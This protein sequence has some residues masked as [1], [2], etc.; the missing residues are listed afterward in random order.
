MD[1]ADGRYWELDC[2]SSGEHGGSAPCLQVL[3]HDEAVKKFKKNGRVEADA[4]A[5]RIGYLVEF[6]LVELGGFGC[7]APSAFFAGQQSRMYRQRLSN[8]YPEKPMMQNL[9]EQ[10]TVRLQQDAKNYSVFLKV[11]EVPYV[12]PPDLKSSFALASVPRLNW[13]A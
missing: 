8:K 7:L 13:A 6:E 11:H 2:P 9:L 5:K 12:P 4:N 10:I 1:K 3:A